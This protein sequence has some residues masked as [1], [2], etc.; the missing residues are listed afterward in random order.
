MDRI[1]LMTQ[2]KKETGGSIPDVDETRS[3]AIE[4]GERMLETE[5]EI[6]GEIKDYIEWLEEKV[7][8]LNRLE[9]ELVKF[10]RKIKVTV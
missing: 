8:I 6:P 10:G 4:D 1:Q 9:K 2:Y 7:D 5:Y 3:I